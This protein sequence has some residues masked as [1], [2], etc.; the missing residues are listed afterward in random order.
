MRLK[1][2]LAAP[3]CL[4]RIGCN[5]VNTQLFEGATDLSQVDFVNLAA[6][7][8]G[9]EVVTSPVRVQGC[10]Q[11]VAGNG[12]ADTMKARCRALLGAKEHT[13][14]LARSVIHGDHQILHSIRHPAVAYNL[15]SVFGHTVMRHKVHHTL[16]TLHH[17]VLAV[18]ALWDDNTKNTKQTF[19]LARIFHANE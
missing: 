14:V 3:T 11:A 16:S 12:L 5:V 7:H 10:K 2:P 6:S 8:W 17:Q 9:G 1:C 19:R 13:D 18:G 4:G 15:M